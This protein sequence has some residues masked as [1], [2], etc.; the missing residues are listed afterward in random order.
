MSLAIRTDLLTAKELSQAWKENKKTAS[1]LPPSDLIQK[2][3]SMTSPV[4]QGYVAT[5]FFL[6]KGMP[7]NIKQDLLAIVQK[8]EEPLHTALKQIQ[9]GECSDDR[10]KKRTITKE[11]NELK[12]SSEPRDSLIANL[13][14]QAKSLK[15]Y[16][17]Q[18]KVLGRIAQ[19]QAD[20]DLTKEIPSPIFAGYAVSKISMAQEKYNRPRSFFHYA[21]ET[22]L[23]AT[24]G[25]GICLFTSTLT[26]ALAITGVAG[27]ALSIVTLGK[28]SVIN[29][30]ANCTA[31]AGDIGRI[32]Y[33]YVGRVINPDFILSQNRMGEATSKIA[34][35]IFN[36][37]ISE[38]SQDGFL[39]SAL[40]SRSLFAVGA[41]IS[42]ATRTADFVLGIFAAIISIVPCCARVKPLNAFALR[43][44]GGLNIINDICAAAR[45]LINP[46]QFVKA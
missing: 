30:L 6:R 37:A 12:K 3:A 16:A 22:I 8:I 32:C 11:L 24:I 2:I 1:S 45:G 5:S 21:L 10:D 46:Q 7:D 41:A 14:L 13:A 28:V 35:P 27:T 18:S 25:A 29:Q 40:I 9:A 33:S 34:A 44:L 15:N 20:L 42:I 26:T 23:N 31:D 19:M 4:V 36:L 39:R 43:Q 17:L 38:A